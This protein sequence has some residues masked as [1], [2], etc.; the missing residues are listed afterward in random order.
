VS[1]DGS[2]PIRFWFRS[3]PSGLQQVLRVVPVI[4]RGDVV[5]GEREDH[6][7]VV[8]LLGERRDIVAILMVL[9]LTGRGLTSSTDVTMITI[10][11]IV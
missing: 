2:V 5:S 9:I 6:L 10:V 8:R 11:I 4:P 1:T 3:Y 7:D